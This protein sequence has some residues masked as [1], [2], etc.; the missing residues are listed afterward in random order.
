M[1]LNSSTWPNSPAPGKPDNA[2]IKILILTDGWVRAV[3]HPI[4]IG[5][6]KV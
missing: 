2:F 6:E 5:F 3:T 1:N 4:A